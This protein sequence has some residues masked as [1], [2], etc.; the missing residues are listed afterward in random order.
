MKTLGIDPQKDLN[1]LLGNSQKASFDNECI[2]DDDLISKAF[3][4]SSTLEEA[5][6]ALKVRTQQALLEEQVSQLV[7]LRQKA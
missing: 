5:L 2:D 1:I 4:E 3:P 6:H 7:T